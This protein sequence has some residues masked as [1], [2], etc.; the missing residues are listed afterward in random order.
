MRASEVM[1]A[2]RKRLIAGEREQLANVLASKYAA[3]AS[4][5]SMTKLRR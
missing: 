2:K 5:S 1:T 3:G 4:K